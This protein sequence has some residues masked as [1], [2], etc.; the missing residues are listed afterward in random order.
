MAMILTILSAKFLIRCTLKANLSLLPITLPLVFLIL[1]FGKLTPM[2]NRRAMRFLTFGDWIRW[3]FPTF[4][5]YRFSLK[6]LLIFKDIPQ[7]SCFWHSFFFLPVA[8]TPWPFF[9]VYRHYKLRSRDL[10]SSYHGLHQFCCLYLIEN[11]QHFL[12]CACLDSSLHRGYH[13]RSKVVAW[14]ISEITNFVWDFLEIQHL[15]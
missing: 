2:E 5:G 1:L 6:L 15:N 11:R 10:L 8:T 4:I 12:W 13:L 3:L 14:L 9:H 7:S